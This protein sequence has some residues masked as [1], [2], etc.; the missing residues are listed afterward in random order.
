[1]VNY[2]GVIKQFY[3]LIEKKPKKYIFNN[4]IHCRCYSNYFTWVP[5]GENYIRKT[6]RI[7][8]DWNY[9]HKTSIEEYFIKKKYLYFDYEEIPRGTDAYGHRFEIYFCK[10]YIIIIQRAW[11]NYLNK[12]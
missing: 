7:S 12:K 2:I 8:D 1:M 4:V 5:N 11:R 3:E 10:S 9:L 6:M